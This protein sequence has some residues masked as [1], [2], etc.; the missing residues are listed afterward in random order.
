MNV[1]EFISIKK[2]NKIVVDKVF[3]L[4]KILETK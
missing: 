2:L 3:H 1:E 4:N